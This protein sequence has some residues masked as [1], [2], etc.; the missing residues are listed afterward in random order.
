MIHA[1]W[2]TGDY[3]QAIAYGQRALDLTAASGDVFEQARVHGTLGTIY[4]FLGDYHRAAGVLRQSIMA[5]EGELLHER[6]SMVVTSVRSCNWLV[7]CLGEL[8]EF[9]EG[10]ACG[11]EAARIAEAAGHLGTAIF[12]QKRLGQLALCQGNLQHA[13]PVLERALA[14]SRTANIP[15]LL[16]GSMQELGLAYALSG[17]VDEALPLLEQSMEQLSAAGQS[18]GSPAM[19]SLGEAYLL[20][21]R[22]GNAVQLAERALTLSRDRKERG[23]Q[24]WALRL[25]GEIARHSYALDIAQA[26]I[27]YHQA[28]ALAEELGMR[29]LQ[30]HCHRG[31]GTLYNQTGQIEQA[32]SELSTAIEMYRDMEMTFWLPETEAA[33]AAV[34]GR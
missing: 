2:R 21:D 7:S 5:L 4:F 23:C 22:L 13:I 28:L 15:L 31:L 14:H 12:T 24:A 27:H 3:D 16:A 17:R 29:P 8:G 20:A 18:D 30:A 32:R 10:L 6:V 1:S 9:A 26:E 19:L 11:E 34:E 33:L 25:L